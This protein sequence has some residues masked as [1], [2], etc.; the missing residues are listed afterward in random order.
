MSRPKRKAL[1][2]MI[3]LSVSIV[4]LGGAP[5]I[6]QGVP[7][8]EQVKVRD[9]PAGA[10]REHIDWG[11]M[12]LTQVLRQ[13]GT[14]ADYDTLMGD[15]GIAFSTLVEMHSTV[16]ASCNTDN[17]EAGPVPGVS[18]AYG[19]PWAL[20]PRLDF[21]S[22][23][24]GRELIVRYAV[25]DQKAT[26]LALS[27]YYDEQLAPIVNDSI[28]R[29]CAMVALDKPS[30]ILAGYER[31]PRDGKLCGFLL[32]SP[33]RA[34]NVPQEYRENIF[35]VVA[36]GAKCDAMDRRAADRLAVECAIDITN[37]VAVIREGAPA[38][39]SGIKAYAAWRHSKEPQIHGLDGLGARRQSAIVYLEA[40][41]KR[42][43]GAAAVH[44]R[45]AAGYYRSMVRLATMSHAEQ[46]DGALSPEE[47]SE[48]DTRLGR[49]AKLDGQAAAELS[50]ALK[51]MT[52]ND[53]TR[54][55]R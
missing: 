27:A 3:L 42:H 31:N 38:C 16:A 28:A 36:L 29:N 47:R 54:R 39:L 33:Q 14:E 5:A 49:L 4:S 9:V 26:G 51:A 32:V 12:S 20:V 2:A 6:A 53:R 15:S 43:D 52:K 10:G 37:D 41:A 55:A 50:T 48:F 1:S 44:L 21:I 11:V 25:G 40:M 46:H 23:S 30:F 35:G 8:A 18:G 19:N 34:S 7:D 24:V 22:Q 45:F 13:S 17:A